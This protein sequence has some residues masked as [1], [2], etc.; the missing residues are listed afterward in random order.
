MITGVPEGGSAWSISS[1]MHRIAY[2]PAARWGLHY[3]HLT[4]ICFVDSSKLLSNITFDLLVWLRKILRDNY[5]L[6]S[7][8]ALWLTF[9][10]LFCLIILCN[11]IYIKKVMEMCFVFEPQRPPEKR[12]Q[13]FTKKCLGMFNNYNKNTIRRQ[14]KSSKWQNDT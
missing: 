1:Y 5:F 3:Y 6:I 4:R 2:T 8:V 13:I 11:I 9:F 14:Q 12:H 10:S 7:E